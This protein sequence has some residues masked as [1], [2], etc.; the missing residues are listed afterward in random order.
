MKIYQGV[1]A[2]SLLPIKKLAVAVL[3]IIMLL[4]VSFSVNIKKFIYIISA[5]N[6][7]TP[8]VTDW[9]F[10]AT[11]YMYIYYLTLHKTSRVQTR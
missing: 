9:D 3:S 6:S 2:R 5:F 8:S 10:F 1:W 11:L 7:V 4:Y